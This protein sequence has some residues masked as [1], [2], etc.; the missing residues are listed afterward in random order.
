M[1]KG[2]FKKRI[3]RKEVTTS[4]HWLR[5]LKVKLIKNREDRRKEK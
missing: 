2:D 4:Y 3:R 1:G 5:D